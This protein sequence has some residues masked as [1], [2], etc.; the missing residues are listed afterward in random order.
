MCPAN[1]L[2][3][4]VIRE[5]SAHSPHNRVWFDQRRG[6][7]YTNPNLEQLGLL[8]V[9][10]LGLHDLAADESLFASAPDLVRL[11]SIVEREAIYREIYDY[12][13]RWMAIRSQV[14]EPTVI[15]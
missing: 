8:S 14:L 11:A 7:R 15:E 9:E 5:L 12:L 2:S 1:R 3:T 4:P 13:R 10:Y 6:W